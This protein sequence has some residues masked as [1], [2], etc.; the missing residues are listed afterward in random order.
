MIRNNTPVVIEA[1]YNGDMI[2]IV[3]GR[4]YTIP[5]VTG[6]DNEWVWHGEV[7]P[8]TEQ[9]D[10]IDYNKP[11]SKGTTWNSILNSWFGSANIPYVIA[12]SLDGEAIPGELSLNCYTFPQLQTFFF[13]TQKQLVYK[14][15]QIR[16]FELG[17]AEPAT[18]TLD[19]SQVKPNQ[20]LDF[21]AGSLAT[22]ELAAWVPNV[23]SAMKL[24]LTEDT[25]V[26]I[27]ESVTDFTG[28]VTVVQSAFSISTYDMPTHEIIIKSEVG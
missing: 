24:N 3:S 9:L 15:G 7:I 21:Q 26:I 4:I 12:P 20:Y 28:T 11:F 10:L 16:F 13:R 2:Q 5:N 6:T 25:A 19:A 8:L 17:D 27:Q 23:T 1:G 14:G 22:L 18:A